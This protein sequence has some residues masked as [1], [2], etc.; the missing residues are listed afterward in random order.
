VAFQFLREPAGL[1]F[2]WRQRSPAAHWTPPLIAPVLLPFEPEAKGRTQHRAPDP[3]GERTPPCQGGAQA[4][5]SG[6]S[7]RRRVR[8]APAARRSFDPFCC[9]ASGLPGLPVA[10]VGGGAGVVVQCRFPPFVFISTSCQNSSLSLRQGRLRA[11]LEPATGPGAPAT[12]SAALGDAGACN[13]SGALARIGA[14]HLGLKS[15]QNCWQIR[16]GGW[17]VLEIVGNPLAAG[18]GLRPWL[19]LIG[20]SRCSGGSCRPPRVLLA[21]IRLRFALAFFLT[22]WGPL[23]LPRPCASPSGSGFSRSPRISLS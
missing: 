8:A 19:G 4:A 1:A 5:H 14:R 6:A 15:C 3:P 7:S 11:L 20:R 9:C 2:C 13:G 12:E 21:G 22:S 10:G 17:K 23:G 18:A 16:S